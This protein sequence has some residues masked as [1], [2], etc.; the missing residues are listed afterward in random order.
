I[1]DDPG[2]Y[3]EY[4]IKNIVSTH[5]TATGMRSLNDF[6]RGSE[7]FF[8]SD[9]RTYDMNDCHHSS[10]GSRYGRISDCTGL[11]LGFQ[12]D[13]KNFCEIQGEDIIITNINYNASPGDGLNGVAG[14][15][16][17]DYAYPSDVINGY[18]NIGYASKRISI[19]NAFI[20]GVNHHA[21]RL[22]NSIDCNVNDVSA[23][24]C[25]YSAVSIEKI[26][27]DYINSNNYPYENKISSIKTRDCDRELSIRYNSKSIIH[28]GVSNN[29]AKT[30]IETSGLMGMASNASNN[31]YLNPAPPINNQNTYIKNNDY[32]SIEATKSDYPEP[33]IGLPYAFTLTD[34]SD[35]NIQTI[36]YNCLIE[37]SYGDYLYISVYAKNGTSGKGSVI[38]QE[39]DSSKNIL[40]TSVYALGIQSDW[41][42]KKITHVTNG[43]DTKYLKIKLAPACGYVGDN[44]SIGSYNFSNFMFGY[45]P[46]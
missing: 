20:N 22:I 28:G 11:Q 7:L 17:T 9:C 42:N 35:T 10:D 27:R 8:I 19:S 2:S 13:T 36:D 31:I 21:V 1:I 16:I 44:T 15:L 12:R 43:S 32:Y 29:N 18:K 23:S 24:H 6:K 25:L 34:L 41:E 33:P 30:R 14:I 38:V 40:L 5:N 46:Q 45:S 39:L 4:T 3:G 26:D 37:S